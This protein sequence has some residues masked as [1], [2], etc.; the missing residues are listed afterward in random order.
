MGSKQDDHNEGQK[1]GAK[2]DFLS[3]YITQNNPFL[4]EDYKEG[5]AHGSEQRRQGNDETEQ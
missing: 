5:Y 4:S 2:G 3:D 1:D